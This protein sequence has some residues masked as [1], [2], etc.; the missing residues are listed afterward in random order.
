[1]ALTAPLVEPL[2]LAPKNFNA[3]IL[4]VHATPATPMPLFP[5]APIVPATWVPWPLSS[6]G[7]PS[8]LAKS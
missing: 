5:T 2:P 7:S 3:M 6:I 1:M 8:L 4:V